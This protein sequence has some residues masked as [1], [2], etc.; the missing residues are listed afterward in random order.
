MFPLKLVT[1]YAV[2]VSG[3]Q[4]KTSILSIPITFA[5]CKW[6]QNVSGWKSVTMVTTYKKVTFRKFF[7]CA[8]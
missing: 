4:H 1:I 8:R 3:G 2:F 5:V 6:C 7:L